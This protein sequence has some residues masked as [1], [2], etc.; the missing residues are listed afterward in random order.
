MLLPLW[1]RFEGNMRFVRHEKRPW[2]KGNSFV[3]CLRTQSISVLLSNYFYFA[4]ISMCISSN[5]DFIIESV[6]NKLR[7]KEGV[8]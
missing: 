6:I 8:K 2:A 3:I 5:A 1:T 4:K 7:P